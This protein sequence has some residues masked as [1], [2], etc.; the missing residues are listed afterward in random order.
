MQGHLQK[1]LQPEQLTPFYIQTVELDIVEAAPLQSIKLSV[2][3]RGQEILKLT[4]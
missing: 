3:R 4:R 2:S 1:H